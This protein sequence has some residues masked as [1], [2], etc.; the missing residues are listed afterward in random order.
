MFQKFVSISKRHAIRHTNT[1]IRPDILTAPLTSQCEQPHNRDILFAKLDTTK[2][3]CEI[4]SMRLLLASWRCDEN[5]INIQ[6]ICRRAAS[7]SPPNERKTE[8]S[9]SCHTDAH[10]QFESY[11]QNGVSFT[12]ASFISLL[13]STSSSSVAILASWCGFHF[14]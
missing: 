5:K 13:S 4:I 9:T 3:V 2:F 12:G 11:S 8:P 10:K 7:L 6:S 14:R 1:H